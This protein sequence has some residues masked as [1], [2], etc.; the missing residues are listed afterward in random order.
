MEKKCAHEH[1]KDESESAEEGWGKP[2]VPIVLQEREIMLS[3]MVAAC[4]CYTRNAE[5]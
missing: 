1:G 2:H 5:V 3:S 4:R